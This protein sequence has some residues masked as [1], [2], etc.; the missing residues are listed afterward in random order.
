MLGGASTALRVIAVEMA[1][2][3]CGD[4]QRSGYSDVHG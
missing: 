1:R 4:R 3:D 2:A